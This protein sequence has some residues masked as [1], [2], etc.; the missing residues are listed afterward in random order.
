MAEN[1][2]EEVQSLR[3]RVELLEKVEFPKTLIPPRE[4]NTRYLPSLR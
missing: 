3:S 4:I 1:M 2:T